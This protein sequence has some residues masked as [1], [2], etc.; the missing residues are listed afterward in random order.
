[1]TLSGKRGTIWAVELWAKSGQTPLFV[2][3]SGYRHKIENGADGIPA[4]VE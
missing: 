1:L 2:L 4:V 3:Y